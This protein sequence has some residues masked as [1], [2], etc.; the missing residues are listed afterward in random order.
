M[1][2][3]PLIP[4]LKSPFVVKVIRWFVG[5]YTKSVKM[6]GRVCMSSRVAASS[7]TAFSGICKAS[8]PAVYTFSCPP[9]SELM[10]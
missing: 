4:L 2:K 8:V 7:N 5:L 9:P 10:V 1:Y 3:E 6:E